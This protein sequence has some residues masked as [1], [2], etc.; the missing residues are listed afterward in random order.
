MM[1]VVGKS[2]TTVLLAIASQVQP[3]AAQQV[4][5]AMKAVPKGNPGDWFSPDDYPRDAYKANRSGRVVLAVGVD[6]TGV[7]VTCNVEKTSGTTILDQRSCELARQHGTFDPATD[8]TGKP[9][10]S[11]YSLS[12]RWVVPETLPTVDL[13]SGKYEETAETEVVVAKDGTIESCRVISRTPSKASNACL[14]VRIG[15]SAGGRY[16]KGNEGV[17]TLLRTR[18][19]ASAVPVP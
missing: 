15:T 17:R 3:V 4:H 13:S 18:V 12:V 8:E 16:V 2:L 1:N 9:V 5:E 11:V 10:A 14:G 19:S 6:S 7:V